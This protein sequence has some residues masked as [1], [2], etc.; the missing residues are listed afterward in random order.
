METKD[1]L[2][3]LMERYIVPAVQWSAAF[4]A[5]SFLGVEPALWSYVIFVV[6]DV[7]TGVM[8]SM[9]QGKPIT[10]REWTRG[11]I[12][13]AAVLM[14]CLLGHPIERFLQVAGVAVE[15]NLERWLPI[16]FTFGEI[17]SVVENLYKCG[18]PIPARVVQILIKGRGVMA[19]QATPEQMEE[20]FHGTTVT[21]ER[22]TT[23]QRGQSPPI[24]TTVVEVQKTSL[25]VTE[26][27]KS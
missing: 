1:D 26:P 22:E 21:T 11:L 12:T 20:L 7:I 4:V 15:L 8:A 19:E 3:H 23:V 6:I 9:Y 2:I 5:S 27:P 16:G 17:L 18:V 24:V 25:P 10:S 14:F 13:K